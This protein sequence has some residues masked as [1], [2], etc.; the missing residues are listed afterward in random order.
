M[1]T[2]LLALVLAALAL[3]WV[4]LLLRRGRIREKYAALWLFV[5][6][7]IGLFA[8][9]PRTAYW[10][11]EAVGVALPSN[12]L[13]VGA[14]GVLFVIALQL[15][16]EVGDLEAQARALAEELALTNLRLDR[17]E[18]PGPD[19]PPAPDALGLAGDRPAP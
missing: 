17:L 3:L 5:S 8:A 10:L 15:S 14:V 7:V 4:L 18:Q 12:L 11:A 16:V 1:S 19:S 6:I 9:F 13:F 2:R